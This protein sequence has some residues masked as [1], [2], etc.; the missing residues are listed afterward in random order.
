MI[1]YTVASEDRERFRTLMEEVQAAC[2]RNGAFQCRLD[3]SLDQPGLFRLDYMVST[4]AEH[5]RQN[6]RMTVDEKQVFNTAWELHAGDSEPVVRHFL[7]IQSPWTCTVLA[8]R[9]APLRILV[10]TEFG[11]YH[12]LLPTR[13]SLGSRGYPGAGAFV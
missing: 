12:V 9:V 8:S 11:S 5:L 7:S 10:E 3:E 2:R 6:M 1:E 13:G 4:W